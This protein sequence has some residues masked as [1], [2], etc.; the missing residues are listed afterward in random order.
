MVL[1]IYIYL[2]YTENLLGILCRIKKCNNIQDILFKIR[3]SISTFGITE[4][5]KVFKRQVAPIDFSVLS[6]FNSFPYI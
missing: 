5:A 2:Y 6:N 4:S 3:K 1:L